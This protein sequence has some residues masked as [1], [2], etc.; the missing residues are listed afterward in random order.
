M[1]GKRTEVLGRSNRAWVDWLPGSLRSVAGAPN[2]GAEEKAGHS[3]RDDR[4]RRA[5]GRRESMKRVSEGDTGVKLMQEWKLGVEHKTSVYNEDWGKR[6]G[7]HPAISRGS[8]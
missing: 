6:I 8:K 5:V 4:Q 3:G 1:A 7:R 2:Y